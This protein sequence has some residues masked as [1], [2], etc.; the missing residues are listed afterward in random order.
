MKLFSAH[1][2]GPIA[3]ELWRRRN[4]FIW[5]GRP[6]P[7][8]LPATVLFADINGFTTISEMLNRKL[9]CAGSR[10]SWTR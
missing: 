3:A 8:R 10:R 4:D 5:Y 1:V 7:V 9:W 2:S 6:I